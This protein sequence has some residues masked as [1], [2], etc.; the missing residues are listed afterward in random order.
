MKKLKINLS[1]NHKVEGNV[2]EN[3]N[4]D[5]IFDCTGNKYLPLKI[6]VFNEK[7]ENDV[8]LDK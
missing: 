8:K 4:F 6:K 2:F 1:L 3:K 7:G 5:L